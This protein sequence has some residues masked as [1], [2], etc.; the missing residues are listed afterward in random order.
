MEL[1]AQR[2]RGGLEATK[3]ELYFPRAEGWRFRSGE[4][5]IY[6]AMHDFWLE[7]LSATVALSAA[8]IDLR[9]VEARGAVRDILRA[10]G[11]EYPR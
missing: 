10:E 5:G 8:G 7:S 4:E 9:I 3:R 11:L 2:S 1:L 6:V